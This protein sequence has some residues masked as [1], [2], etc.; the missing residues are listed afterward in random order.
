[1][2]ILIWIFCSSSFVALIPPCV[3]LDLIIYCI[4][5]DVECAVIDADGWEGVF[6]SMC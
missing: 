5:L 4:F 2:I 6:M 1:M 3:F